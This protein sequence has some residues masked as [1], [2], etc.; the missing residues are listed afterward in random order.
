MDLSKL[1]EQ[2]IKEINTFLRFREEVGLY[3]RLR[4]N[5]AYGKIIVHI[6]DG[7]VVAY[8]Q[9]RFVTAA[10]LKAEPVAA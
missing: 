10:E 2:D 8:D 6:K 1:T 4:R 5:L 3:L 9:N 7:L